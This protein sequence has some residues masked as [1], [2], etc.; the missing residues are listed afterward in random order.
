MR[1]IVTRGLPVPP[2]LPPKVDTLVR[3]LLARDDRERWRRPQVEA[4]LAGR[5]VRLP[6]SAPGGARAASPARKARGRKTAAPRAPKPAWEGYGPGDPFRCLGEL[7]YDPRGLA[8]RFNRDDAGWEAGA[9]LASFG[10]LDA[11]L[12]G[13]AG[14][15]E[16]WPAARRLAG[17]PHETLFAFIRAF[18]P[19][20]PPAF[21]G[22]ELSHQN[23]I[24]LVYERLNPPGG[25]DGPPSDGVRRIL[26]PVLD[27][28]LKNFPGIAAASGRPLDEW[29][30]AVIS[31]GGRYD[32]DTLMG[33]FLASR[34][35]GAFIWGSSGP[36]EG[37]K[38]LEFVLDAGCPLL[39]E[40]WWT[41][42]TP[43]GFRFPQALLDG[44]LDSPAT[45]KEGVA[46][47]RKALASGRY[48][49]KASLSDGGDGGPEG[50]DRGGDGNPP[51]GG[52]L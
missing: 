18:A 37:I 3:G 29:A 35:P 38:A 17:T 50:G 11:W 47:V 45:Y 48:T 25:R 9:A 24:S 30:E 46:A 6:E 13:S 36:R 1:E 39:M 44:P 40:D 12:E 2:G 20:S 51:K 31:R 15:L 32:W 52:G 21:R 27:G 5:P 22:T 4:L 41:R 23:I 14:P 10:E 34:L 16:A 43:P 7:F 28:T 19:E 8:L 26:G 33:A 49:F 42:N